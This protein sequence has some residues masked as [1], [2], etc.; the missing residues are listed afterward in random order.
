M[1]DALNVAEAPVIFSHAS[2]RA[3]ADY[4]RNVPDSILRRLPANGGVLMQL[5]FPPDIGPATAERV[6]R[7]TE[8]RESL[9]ARYGDDE[10]R[11]RQEIF[12][13][14]RANP[15]RAT[16]ADVA[17]HIEHIRDV[18]G[19]DHVGIGSDFDGIGAYVEGLED[20]STFPALFMELARRGSSDEDLKKLPGE[21][22][23]RANARPR[24]RRSRSWTGGDGK[25]TPMRPLWPVLVV[26][27]MLLG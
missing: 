13:W 3:V 12:N 11:L 6:K 25:T 23:L 5:F 9:E 21:N 15:V 22:L 19:F 8:M 26:L 14:Y 1:N 10:E 27:A 20:V 16:L 2:A 18:A 24:P 17:D 7:Q 4:P